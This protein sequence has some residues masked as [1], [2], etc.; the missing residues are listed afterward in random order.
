MT[1]MR[2]LVIIGVLFAA[3]ALMSTVQAQ[4]LVL[5]SDTARTV[6]VSSTSPGVTGCCAR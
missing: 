6:E 5:E 3:I 2:A 1:H 4:G